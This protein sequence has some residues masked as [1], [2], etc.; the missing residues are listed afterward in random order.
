MTPRPR[1]AATAW[2]LGAT[3]YLA[4]E[5]VTASAY[6][7]SYSYAH[8]YISDL[9]VPG[10]PLAALMNAGFAAQGVLFLLG[11][12]LASGSRHRTLT[13]C[14]AANAIGNV[15]VGTVPA[16]E[17]ALHLVGATLAIVGGNAAALAGASLLPGLGYRLASRALG[18]VGLLSLVVLAAQAWIGVEVLP[19]PVWERASVYPILAWQVFAAL[20]LSAALLPARRQH[21]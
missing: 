12:V 5:A 9:G 11:A 1:A 10:Q 4:A 2:I 8:D 17:G 16:G 3:A 14:A 13:A 15:L 21:P 20:A 7:P 19:S 6:R 18:G